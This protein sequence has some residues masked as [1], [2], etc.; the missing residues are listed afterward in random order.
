[1]VFS[2]EGAF[3]RASIES[4]GSSFAFFSEK[5]FFL[6][7]VGLHFPSEHKLGWGSV[8]WRASTYARGCSWAPPIISIFLAEGEGDA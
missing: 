2:T 5:K 6:K 4:V 1:M 7:E 8:S 3:P